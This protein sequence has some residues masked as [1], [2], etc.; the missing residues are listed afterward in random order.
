[1]AARAA[2]VPGQPLRPPQLQPP[3]KLL[4][5]GAFFPE[6]RQRFQPPILETR[7]GMPRR[8]RRFDVRSMRDR[9][10]DRV[11]DPGSSDAN[12]DDSGTLAQYTGMKFPVYGQYVRRLF[13]RAKNSTPGNISA[14]DACFLEGRIFI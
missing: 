12:R 11:R 8:S 5:Y 6:S 3:S 7:V 14:A 13:L 4:T 2:L 1:M 9:T 10:R